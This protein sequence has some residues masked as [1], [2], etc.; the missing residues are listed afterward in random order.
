MP[1][2]KEVLTNPT[3][4]LSHLMGLCCFLHF[5]GVHFRSMQWKLLCPH[6]CHHI[7]PNKLLILSYCCCYFIRKVATPTP[8]VPEHTWTRYPIAW[9]DIILVEG[10]QLLHELLSPN[11]LVEINDQI[12]D[13]IDKASHQPNKDD[14]K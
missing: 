4:L 14:N 10:Q 3:I 9:L 11:K 5:L 8:K 7:H 1:K 13:Q 2:E 6:Q 12:K